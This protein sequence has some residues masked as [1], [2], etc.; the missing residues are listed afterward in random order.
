MSHPSRI[1]LGVLLFAC[2][3]ASPV[4]GGQAAISP[5]LGWPMVGGPNSY[6]MTSAFDL[7]STTTARADWTGW[8]SSEQI[9]G[10]GHA[11]DGHTGS[12][13]GV[14]TGTDV[15]AIADGTV[16]ALRESVPN[17]DHSDTGNYLIL[18]H[19]SIGGRNYR[20]RYW[21]L[22]QDGVLATGVGAA[23]TKGEHV[24]E[25]DNTGNS[26]GPHLHYA[27]SPLP[28]DV[29]T[30]GFYHG[31]WENDEFYVQDGYPC[32]VY[33]N[34]NA[35]TLN[36]REGNSTTYNIL[37]TLPQ[38]AQIVASQRNGWYRVYLPLPPARA[39]ESRTSGGGLSAGY[40]ETGSWSDS[41]SKTA[42]SDSVADANRTILS[43]SGSRYSTFAT[44]GDLGDVAALTFATP[45]QRGL[46]DLYASWPSDANAA[47][48][49]YRVT[50]SNATRDVFVDQRG[51]FASTGTGTK[52]APYIIQQNP[53]VANQTTIGAPS[54]WGSYSPSGSGIPEN[55]PE[56]LYRFELRTTS[57]VT[58]SVAHAGYP[59]KDVDVQ[60]LNA[61]SNT[62]CIYRAD[63]SFAATALA[64]GT[65][66]IS[67]DSYGSD[68]SRATDY[69]LT[70]KFSETE[71][72]ADSWVKLGEFFYNPSATGRIEVR[73]DSVI[74]TLDPSAEGRVYADTFKIVPRIYRRT[75]W[76][77]DTFLSRIN[78]AQNPVAIVGIKTDESASGDSRVIDDY[79]EV[80]IYAAPA[81]GTLNTSPIVGKA[82]TGQRF[83]CTHRSG[84]W[85][86]VLLTN[87]TDSKTGWLLGDQLFGYRTANLTSPY[88]QWMIY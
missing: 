66:Y 12:D 80:P 43:G 76:A 62:A 49:T 5:A 18:S 42:V 29:T 67:V 17:D 58:V 8:R 32:L 6:R 60:L 10:S 34:V 57:N 4:R 63:F 52:S 59:T 28:G 41:T 22:A 23:V 77:S 1:C 85:Y 24:A 69:T 51:R 71:P 86:Q 36:C 9:A 26:T 20:S 3:A 47:H 84:D 39:Y 44:T 40:A 79:A 35:S 38:G 65:Y 2:V 73:E 37:T 33:V 81:I 68:A 14:P 56:R 83:V 19:A 61:L 16:Y 54:E 45:N 82:V 53:F 88:A 27:I 87:G 74:G 64:P 72:F 78:T 15:L 46:Y 21:H 50:D 31:W 48:V 7:D 13:F 30:C 70:V 11:Y 75:G 55:G 25:S